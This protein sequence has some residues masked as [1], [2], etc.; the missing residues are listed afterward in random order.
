MR[1]IL[2]AWRESGRN[3]VQAG[4][5]LSMRESW[6]PCFLYTTSGGIKG[7]GHGGKCPQSEALPPNL[8]PRQEKKM[9]KISHFRQIFGFCSLRIAFCPLD[10]PHKKFLVPPLYTT[11]ESQ[12]VYFSLFP[13]YSSILIYLYV[14][15]A[16]TLNC[17]RGVPWYP[18][19][20]FSA[21]AF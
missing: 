16:L 1:E 13:S 12:T 20:G 10:A 18:T 15:A 5:S 2:H 11:C 19:Y 3:S 7:G 9:A 8:P 21:L 4:D 6:K 14:I 17:I